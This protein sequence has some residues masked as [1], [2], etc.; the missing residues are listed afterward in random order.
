L[1]SPPTALPSLSCLLLQ[2]H[3]P[4]LRWAH[5]EMGIQLEPTESIFGAD[6]Q[7]GQ[8]MAVER[9]LMVSTGGRVGGWVCGGSRPL[10]WLR[11]LGGCPAWRA[12][13][14]QRGACIVAIMRNSLNQC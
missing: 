2:L 5:Q 8:V 11:E 13:G 3:G 7:L 14:V 12:G 10:V 6:L 9:Y 4:I 1:A